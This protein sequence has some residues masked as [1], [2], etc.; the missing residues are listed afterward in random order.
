MSE[1]VSPLRRRMIEDMTLRNLSATTQT[2]YIHNIKKFS[3]YFD[4]SPDCLGLENVRAMVPEMRPL[5]EL[6]PS[7]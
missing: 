1:C 4:R 6:R 3:Q 7:G 2:S 5:S